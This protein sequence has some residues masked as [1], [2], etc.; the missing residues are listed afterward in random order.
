VKIQIDVEDMH[1]EGT[2]AVEEIVPQV[3]QFLIQAVPA[4][5][6]AKKLIYIPDLAGL[7]DRVSEFARMTNTGQLLLTRIN[8]PAEKAITILLFMAQLA[9]KMGK[10][11]GD[12]LTIEEISTGVGRAPKTIRNV[13]VQLQRAGF[14]D[15]ADRGRYRITSKG[16][17]ELERSLT[18][19]QSGGI[20]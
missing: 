2:G 19:V 16:L 5:D 20:S 6:I 13:L 9:G 1:F 15:R 12:S 7:A 8:L 11:E 4:Y 14:I 18:E 10:R 17:M 3:M